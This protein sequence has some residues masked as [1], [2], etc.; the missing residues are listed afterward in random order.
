MTVEHRRVMGAIPPPFERGPNAPEDAGDEPSHKLP[1]ALPRPDEPH[2]I[3]RD[4][5]MNQPTMT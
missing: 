5:S 3:I 4:S 1:V 2:G